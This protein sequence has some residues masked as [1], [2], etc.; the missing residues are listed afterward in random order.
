MILLV[1]VHLLFRRCSEISPDPLQRTS[2][3]IESRSPIHLLLIR[4]T[5]QHAFVGCV[6]WYKTLM[7]G[8]ISEATRHHAARFGASTHRRNISLLNMIVGVKIRIYLDVVVVATWFLRL[9]IIE[10]LTTHLTLMRNNRWTVLVWILM[11]P[12]KTPK[13]SITG[14]VSTIQLIIPILS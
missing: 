7:F 10:D 14:T 1:V 4:S 8:H 11:L 9:H 12:V 13:V 6:F 5:H 3:I 2:L